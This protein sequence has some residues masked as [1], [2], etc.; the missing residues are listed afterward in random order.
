MAHLEMQGVRSAAAIY[1]HP[2]HPMLVPF[3]IAFLVGALV[4][5][6]VFWGTGNPFWARFSHWLIGAGFVMGALAAVAGLIDFLSRERIRALSAAWVHFIGNAI[7]LLLTLW[8]LVQRTGG[9][10]AAIL[11]LGIILSAIVVAVFLVTGWLGGELV[12]RHRIGLIEG[13][14]PALARG[15]APDVSYAG[16]RPG[17]PPNQA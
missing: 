7:A 14:A 6:C 15:T 5:D 4:T 12:F 2:I 11:P 17:E 10:P 3:P 16:T 13:E 9:D 1:G 8:N